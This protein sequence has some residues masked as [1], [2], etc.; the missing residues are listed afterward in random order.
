MGFPFKLW[1][2]A[3]ILCLGSAPHAL[4]QSRS[5]VKHGEGWSV[6]QRHHTAIEPYRLAAVWAARANQAAG[7][8]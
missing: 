3:M 7:T 8:R 5:G 1:L 6:E 4:A 2:A